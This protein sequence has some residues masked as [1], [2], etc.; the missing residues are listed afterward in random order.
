MYNLATPLL[1]WF[2]WQGIWWFGA[3][4][5]LLAFVIYAMVVSAP[6]TTDTTQQRAPASS[7]SF[8]RLL[9]NPTSWIL[10]LVFA[11][12]QLHFSRLCHLGAHLLQSSIWSG[13]GNG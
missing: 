10:A 11:T 3:A 12:F 1:G 7:G 2:G 4:F 13:C 6:P 5:A 8:G 9:F